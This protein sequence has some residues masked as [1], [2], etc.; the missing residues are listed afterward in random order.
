MST[1][2]AYGGG[3]EIPLGGYAALVA[4]FG[5]AL[6]AVLFRARRRGRVPEHVPIDDAALMGVATHAL[7]RI[8]TK[9]WVTAPL[10]APFV[11][12]VRSRGGGEVDETSRGRGLRRAIGNL[13]T[14]PYC[15]G[16]WVALGLIAG[17]LEAPRA[18]RTIAWLSPRSRSRTGSIGAI[19]RSARR[20]RRWRQSRASRRSASSTS[21]TRTR[22]AT[23][24]Q[25]RVLVRHVDISPDNMP[26]SE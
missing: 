19:A 23:K 21:R 18:T 3:E 17:Y 5:L 25:E 26:E 11:R 14:C 8:V 7:T 2:E 15:T 20:A 9:D 10:R 24:H 1:K 6:G 4:A 16:P 12:Y 22:R 13:L